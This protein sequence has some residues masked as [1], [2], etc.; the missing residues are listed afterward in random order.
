MSASTASA[1]REE[2]HREIGWLVLRLGKGHGLPPSAAA[3]GGA[4]PG[5]VG[6]FRFHAKAEVLPRMESDTFIAGY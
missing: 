2:R 6:R 3:A 5:W 4:H 1:S